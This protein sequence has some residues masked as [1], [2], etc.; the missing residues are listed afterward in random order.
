[1]RGREGLSGGNVLGREQLLWKGR[2]LGSSRHQS[3]PF[4]EKASISARISLL[5]T[6][7][8]EGENSNGSAEDF[9]P[10]WIHQAIR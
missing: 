10:I 1:M 3:A 2:R 9:L 8:D 4:W 5:S 7:K 6:V